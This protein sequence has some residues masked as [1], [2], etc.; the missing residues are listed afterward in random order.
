MCIASGFAEFLGLDQGKVRVIS[1][2]VGG[3]FGYKVRRAS[4]RS[5]ASPGWR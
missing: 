5:C 2:D 1:P 4:R 3:G